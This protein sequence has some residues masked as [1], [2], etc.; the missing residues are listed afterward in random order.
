MGRNIKET[1]EWFKHDFDMRNDDKILAVRRKFKHEGYSIWN[2]LLEK[3]T[4]SKDFELLYDDLN[5]ELWAGDFD[6]EPEKLKQIIDY[7]IVLKLIESDDNR[8]FSPNQKNRFNSLIRKRETERN[9]YSSSEIEENS[10]LDNESTQSRV[11]KSR[12]DKK[13]LSDSEVF[14]DFRKLY[15][16]IKKS[17]QTE[18]E[19]FKKKTKDWKEVLPQL[20]EIIKKQIEYRRRL[21]LKNEFV[22]E[23]KHLQTWI[24]KRCWEDEIPNMEGSYVLPHSSTGNGY[25]INPQEYINGTPPQGKFV[26]KIT[27]DQ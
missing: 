23:P 9:K 17:N 6:I 1:A 14:D 22:P 12:V 21:A 24:N 19:N 16:G 10:I 18:F 25:A 7:F 11:E 20:T 4:D 8:I 15:F 27:P 13:T 3:L 5:V 2:M 26:G